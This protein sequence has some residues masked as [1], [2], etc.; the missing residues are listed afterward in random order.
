M[1]PA[2]TLQERRQLLRQRAE[3]RFVS[4]DEFC[5]LLLGFKHL[6]RSDESAGDLKGLLDPETG[7]R[8]LIEEEKLTPPCPQ[9]S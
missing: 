3:C 2:S 6:V 8:F 5:E 7:T 4:S 9:P 1:M